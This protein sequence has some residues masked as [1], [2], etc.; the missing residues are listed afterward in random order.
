MA[1]VRTSSNA[2]YVGEDYDDR[3]MATVL[4]K[5]WRQDYRLVSGVSV[6]ESDLFGSDLSVKQTGRFSLI[7]VSETVN[8]GDSG[9][10]LAVYGAT[11]L[12]K[13]LCAIGGR[14]DRAGHSMG[15]VGLM[16][17]YRVCNWC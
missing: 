11:S 12:A 7:S 8:I 14:F 16:E 9:S 4:L 10:G 6:S 3:I 13:S 1:M 2:A 15:L 5:L 17:L